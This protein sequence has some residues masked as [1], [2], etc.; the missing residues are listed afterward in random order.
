MKKELAHVGNKILPQYNLFTSKYLV[1]GKNSIIFKFPTDVN[2]E[3][4]EIFAAELSLQFDKE[5]FE[6]YQSTE[7]FTLYSDFTWMT[8]KVDSGA[9]NDST[10][11]NTNEEVWILANGSNFKFFKAQMYGMENSEAVGIWYPVIDSNNVETVIFRKDIEISGEI[12]NAT[13]KCIGQN[14]LS[15]WINDQLIVEDKGIVI[16]DRLKKIQPFEYTVNQLIPGLNTIEIKVDG[17]KEYKGL[18]FEMT[19]RAKKKLTE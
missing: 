19:Y 15:I 7:Q 9:V 13:L 18:I 10:V 8:Q 16:D 12:M 6:H 4:V 2:K 11:S 3:K 17:G 1:D 5:V 14:T